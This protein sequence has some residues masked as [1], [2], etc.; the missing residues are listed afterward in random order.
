[1]GF[2]AIFYSFPPE[3]EIDLKAHD[4]LYRLPKQRLPTNLHIRW[5]AAHGGG[6]ESS[7]DEE[8]VEK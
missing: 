7:V 4:Y 3:F 6:A 2:G 5:M 8:A 1:M